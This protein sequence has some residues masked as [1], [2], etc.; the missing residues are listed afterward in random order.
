MAIPT[1]VMK[2]AEQADEMIRQME[3]AQ[4]GD[5]GNP[6]PG[7][8]D[9]K[10][11]QPAP[12]TGHPQSTPIAHTAAT[13]DE[14][15]ETWKQRYLTVQ[16]K[17][18][19]EVPRM[20]AEIRTLRDQLQA[21]AARVQ[22]LETTAYAN[23][24]HQAGAAQKPPA[25]TGDGQ[26]QLR[27]R[28]KDLAAQYDDGQM[29][30]AEYEDRR[31]AILDQIDALRFGR[32]RQEATAA[33]A[34]ASAEDRFWS[35]LDRMVP[36]WERINAD[37]AFKAWLVQDEGLTGRSRNEFL[38]EAQNNLNAAR[39]ASFF[40]TFRGNQPSPQPTAPTVPDHLVQPGKPKGGGGTPV[41][42][43]RI[44]T[45]AEIQKMATDITRGIPGDQRQRAEVQ[46]EIDRAFAEN[47]V[48]G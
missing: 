33:A 9:E 46:S 16:G 41:P 35:D 5:T 17:Y 37:P 27:A 18:D 39:V 12:E 25:D 45:Q 21:S 15:A 14:H 20:A 23:T 34:K 38:V 1:Q 40:I 10:G 30:F 47:R 28:L 24:S 22:Q 6:A 43:G 3:A 36:D 2:Q 13:P 32:I 7:S 29:T 4:D 11:Q 44:Y 26:Q 42:Q 19:A 48:K 31:Q 8:A